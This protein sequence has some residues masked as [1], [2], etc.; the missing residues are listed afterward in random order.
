MILSFKPQF[1]QKILDGAKI[2]TI[3]KDEANRWHIGRIIHFATAIATLMER[4]D[5][6]KRMN[7]TAKDVVQAE[8]IRLKLVDD[9]LKSL[10]ND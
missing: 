5:I 6:A 3:R 4:P 2:H 8:K 7:M 10:A 9:F 1:K